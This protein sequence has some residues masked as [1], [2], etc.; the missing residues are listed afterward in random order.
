MNRIATLLCL[1]CLSASVTAAELSGVFVEESVQSANG[2]P[3]V[4]NGMGLR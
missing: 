2:E 4:L 1:Y 3:L